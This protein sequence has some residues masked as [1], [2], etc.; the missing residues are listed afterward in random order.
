MK[1]SM[2]LICLLVAV[3][4]FAGAFAG[5][6]QQPAEGNG[7]PASDAGEPAAGDSAAKDSAGAAPAAEGKLSGEGKTIGVLFDFLQVERRVLAKN[8]LEQ[9][10]KEAGL[11]LIFLDANGDEKVQMQQ[12]ENLI[13]EEVDALVV[14]AQNAEAAKPMVDQAKEAGIPFIAIDRMIPDADIDY[15]IG[16]DND[17]IGDMMAQYVYDL[18]PKGNYVL[19]SGAPTDPN[20]QVYKDGWMR[21]IG[22]AVDKGDIKIV[23]DAASEN[24]DPNI[25]YENVENFLTVNND[26]VDV[27]LAMNDGTA[28][29]V[30]Q[31]LKGRNLNGKVLVTGQDGEL[32]ACQR[33]V[34]GD[35]TM[36][37]WKPDN[38]LSRLVID[39]CL[40]IVNGQEPDINGSINNGVKDVPAVLVDPVPVGKDN[41]D[42]TIIAAGYYP[43]EDV[44]SKT[45]E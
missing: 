24:W 34:A 44:Y 20:C 25:A 6:A 16:M 12:A 45:A 19:I 39:A 17:A 18:C 27:I 28:G 1:K 3:L 5:C 15:Y 14:L 30:V 37:V 42:S 33:I 4:M 2:K 11:E 10:A 41:M 35:Q 26:E 38:E 43:K 40:K 21:V 31:A 23:G 8:Y 32:A 36:T 7:A 29:G 13:T 9:Y 22:D